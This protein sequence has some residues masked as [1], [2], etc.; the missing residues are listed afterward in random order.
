MQLMRSGAVTSHLAGLLANANYEIIK[1]SILP[2]AKIHPTVRTI[3]LETIIDCASDKV[4]NYRP[5]RFM[6]QRLQAVLSPS[7]PCDAPPP[8]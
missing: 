1:R 4:G 3:A 5:K 6:T 7:T 2:T 8:V